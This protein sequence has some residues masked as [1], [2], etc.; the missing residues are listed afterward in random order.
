MSK[1]TRQLPA[2]L[3]R[4]HRRLLKR[5]Q[6]SVECAFATI[7]VF[8]LLCPCIEFGRMTVDSL[9]ASCA[10]ADLARAAAVEPTLTRSDQQ[11][12][13]QA[14]YPTLA[15]ATT[16]TLT[17]SAQQ[18]NSYTH[19]FCPQSGE[20]L[21]RPSYTAHRD[22]TATLSVSRRYITPTGMLL[23]P[24]IGAPTDHYEAHATGSALQ[25]ETVESG[26]W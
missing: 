9:V 4:Q 7:M 12:F 14:A 20:T 23:A 17:R 5:G 21:T 1:T 2:H 3:F 6:A 11:A 8:T 24:V 25:D 10:A 26:R 18:R 22:V 16:F 15:G 19:H 13:L